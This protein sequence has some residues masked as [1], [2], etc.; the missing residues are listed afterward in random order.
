MLEARQLRQGLQQ[1]T[2]L[3]VDEAVHVALHGAGVGPCDRPDRPEG[4]IIATTFPARWT[5]N[6]VRVLDLT[7]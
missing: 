7:P 4:G 5:G 2:G 1:G 6:P 3:E